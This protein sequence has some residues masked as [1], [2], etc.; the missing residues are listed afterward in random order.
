M[1]TFYNQATLYIS[2]GICSFATLYVFPKKLNKS[3]TFK[4]KCIF[5][6]S[7]S[8]LS[9]LIHE[10]FTGTKNYANPGM[11]RIAK[12]LVLFYKGSIIRNSAPE[13]TLLTISAFPL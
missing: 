5:F 8:L 2:E 13:S 1:A 9:S 12:I 4:V 10:G 3:F 11:T 7:D 6:Q